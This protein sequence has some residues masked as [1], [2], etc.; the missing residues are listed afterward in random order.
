MHIDGIYTTDDSRHSP[1][2]SAV[3]CYVMSV[4]VIKS[5]ITIES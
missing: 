1:R 2:M 5:R 4:V 3:L